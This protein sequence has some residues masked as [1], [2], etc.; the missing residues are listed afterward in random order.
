MEIPKEATIT[1]DKKDIASRKANEVAFCELLLAMKNEYCIQ[2]VAE[3]I[4][5]DLPSGDSN[6]AWG[7]LLKIYEPKE[8]ASKIH[9]WDQ[10]SN[11]KHTNDVTCYEWVSKMEH[12][13]RKFCTSFKSIITDEDFLLRVLKNL[14][15]QGFKE[16]K[17]SFQRQ[18]ESTVDPLDLESMKKQL[19]MFE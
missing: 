10:L 14:P 2:V 6:L 18:L 9:L 17:I 12:I 13:H 3:S 1:T 8:T 7:R 4:S 5:S 15:M 19:R 11:L 16:L